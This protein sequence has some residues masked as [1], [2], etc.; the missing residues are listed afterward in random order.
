MIG[1]DGHPNKNAGILPPVKLPRRM[2]A[3]SNI[4]FKAP[5]Q[6]NRQAELKLTV[7]DV[8][9][10]AGKSGDIVLIDIDRTLTQDGNTKIFERQTLVYAAMHKPGAALPIPITPVQMD[11]P[12]WTPNSVELL[13]FSAATFN[14]HRIHYDLPYAQT[15]EGYPALVVQ[16]PLTATK[17][18][19][20]AKARFAQ[21]AF[22]DTFKFRALAPLFADQTVKF[23]GQLEDGRIDARRCDGASAMCAYWLNDSQVQR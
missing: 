14:S 18:Y 22:P 21:R 11:Q 17:L 4:A 1:P 16:G 9:H 10:R 12:N 8:T 5:L 19:A 6:L 2:F 15:Q 20:F 3:A 7:A 13:R 23:E